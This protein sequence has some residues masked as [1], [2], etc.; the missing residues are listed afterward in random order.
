MC[1]NVAWLVV[2]L[3]A[4][5]PASA[6]SSARRILSAV[7]VRRIAGKLLVVPP[8]FNREK[9]ALALLNR[10]IIPSAEEL[11]FDLVFHPHEREVA[12]SRPLDV[13]VIAVPLASK[14]TPV[15]EAIDSIAVNAPPFI[16][17]SN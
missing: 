9:S 7:V 11:S 13:G 14:R 4:V 6:L 8:K 10:L 16:E 12:I 2:M 17:L 15:V 3:R 5:S 1:I